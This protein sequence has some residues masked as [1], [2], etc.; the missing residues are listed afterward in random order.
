MHLLDTQ[1]YNTTANQ[2]SVRKAKP[3]FPQMSIYSSS[4]FD[5]QV[6]SLKK[7]ELKNSSFIHKFT[8]PRH[9][10]LRGVRVLIYAC[11]TERFLLRG[12]RPTD[13]LH[14]SVPT[15]QIYE[16]RD[17][18]LPRCR[19]YRGPHK[20]FFPPETAPWLAPLF[21]LPTLP[22]H[23][24]F[25]SYQRRVN[26]PI[27]DKYTFKGHGR[28][29]VAIKSSLLPMPSSFLPLSSLSSSSLPAGLGVP[30]VAVL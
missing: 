4:T 12:G 2:N 6:T 23:H 28:S 30:S 22:P 21:S 25:E 18:G 3:L 20:T 16:R 14:S 8:L 27:S 11:G 24:H 15:G 17:L 29:C 19:F 26:T 5:W 7:A 1:I 13:S 10:P 9:R